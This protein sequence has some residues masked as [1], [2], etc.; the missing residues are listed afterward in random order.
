MGVRCI[1]DVYLNPNQGYKDSGKKVFTKGKW[2]KTRHAN[3]KVGNPYEP[4]VVRVLRAK[5]DL[6]QQHI[7]KHCTEGADNSFYEKHFK[8][9]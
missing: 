3:I 4:N 9:E 1:E 5:N 7:I 6:E 8:E 2:Y